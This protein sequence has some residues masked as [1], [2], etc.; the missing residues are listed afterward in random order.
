MKE[1][2]GRIA[3]VTG[4]GSGM[5]RELVRLL[6][7]EGCHVAMCD[8]SRH[9]MAETRRQCEAAGLPQGLRITA[10]LADVSSEADLLRFR[11]EA[12]DE[13]ATDRIHLLFNNAGIGGGGSMVANSRDEWERTFNICWGGVYLATRA[14]LPLLQAA[15]AAHIV[16]TSSMNGF[17]ASVGPDAP[18]TAYSAAKFAVRGF[19]EALMTDLRLNAPHIKVS[20][21]MPGHIGTGFRT[22]SLKVQAG[23]E[24]DELDARQIAQARARLTSMGR[25][26]SAL[27]DDQLKAMLAER[28]R[29]FL[30]DAPTSAAEAAAIILDGVKADRWRILVGSDAQL[31]DR[32]VREDPEHAYEEQFFARFAAAAGWHPGR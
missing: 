29:R 8:V 14:F 10:H 1:L 24:S 16:N 5:G 2:S 15:D 21:V 22:N 26:S 25:D 4:G 3:V 32:M 20:V 28:A 11:D 23:N 12:R 27:S 13:H 7:A 6:V 30:T 19:T 31:M 18:H 17:W 9:G